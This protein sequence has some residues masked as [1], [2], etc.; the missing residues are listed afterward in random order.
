LRIFI[1]SSVKPWLAPV[2]AMSAAMTAAPGNLPNRY[3]LE[4]S[5]AETALTKTS[6]SGS[7]IASRAASENARSPA[8]YQRS[9]W[10]SS[11]RRMV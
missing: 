5:Q 2:P 4:I 8:S 9:M 7:A 6:L 11:S 1:G 10:V 3:L